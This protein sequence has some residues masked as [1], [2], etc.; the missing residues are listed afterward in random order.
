M[1]PC[2]RPLTARVVVSPPLARPRTRTRRS[3]L[4]RGSHLP[5]RRRSHRYEPVGPGRWKAIPRAELGKN[6]DVAVAAQAAAAEDPEAERTV[7]GSDH[8]HVSVRSGGTNQLGARSDAG[9]EGGGSDWET[10]DDIA[11]SEFAVRQKDPVYHSSLP[12]EKIKA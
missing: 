4:Y 12:Y 3:H 9:S 1:C 10:D 7:D 2:P 5:P 11:H 6:L 8:G